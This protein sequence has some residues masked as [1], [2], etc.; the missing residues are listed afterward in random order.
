MEQFKLKVERCF[1]L[2]F[3]Q[4]G[5]SHLFVTRRSHFLLSERLLSF[6]NVM[7][8]LKSARWSAHIVELSSGYPFAGKFCCFVVC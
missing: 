6:N 5:G 7:I 3:N 2:I 8:T 1:A 4:W